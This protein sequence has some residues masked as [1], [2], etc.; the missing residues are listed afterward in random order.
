VL[1]VAVGMLTAGVGG[2]MDAGPMTCLG[3][4][5]FALGVL[6][7][8]A[9]VSASSWLSCPRCQGKATGGHGCLMVGLIVC[10]FPIGLLF[11]LIRPDYRCESCGYRFKA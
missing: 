9:G 1:L 4:A 6:L 2:G 7:G 10:T 11:L 5:L 3:V 8:L